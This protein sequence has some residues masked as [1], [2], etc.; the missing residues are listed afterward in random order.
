MGVHSRCLDWFP[1]V[2]SMDSPPSQ[3]G[4]DGK[5]TLPLGS[6]SSQPKP[7]RVRVRLIRVQLLLP[8]EFDEAVQGV[9]RGF[10]QLSAQ[11]LP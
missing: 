9:R 5:R 10:E 3:R 6:N 7:I 11:P 2:T 8:A 4:T 1:G